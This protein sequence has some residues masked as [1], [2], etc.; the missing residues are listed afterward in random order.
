MTLL[1][2]TG[3]VPALI[4]K[5]TVLADKISSNIFRAVFWTQG[6]APVILDTVYLVAC[7]P[8]SDDKQ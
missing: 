5:T 3:R 2:W 4:T 1:T 8:G 7:S 6:L